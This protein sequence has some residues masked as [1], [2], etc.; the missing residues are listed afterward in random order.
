VSTEEIRRWAQKGI[1]TVHCHN[2]GDYYDDG[3]FWR[4]GSYPCG[5]ETGTTPKSIEDLRLQAVRRA[6]LGGA[7][8]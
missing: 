2:D 6:N 5:Q 4:D 8:T 3:L 7:R 1:Q